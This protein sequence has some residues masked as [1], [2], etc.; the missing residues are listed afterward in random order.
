[1]RKLIYFFTFFAG[2]AQPPLPLQEFFP[3]QP[4]SPVLH[5]P[6]PLHSFLPEQSCFAAFFLP[7]PIVVS[8]CPNSAD[9]ASN[10]AVAVPRAM[11]NFLRFI[12]GPPFVVFIPDRNVATP[13]RS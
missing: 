9:P 5:P 4:A 13:H 2:T 10:P 12:Y 8:T 3:L 1:M 7:A 6:W 11:L